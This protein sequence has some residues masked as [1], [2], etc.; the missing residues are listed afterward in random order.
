MNLRPDRS[1][2]RDELHDALSAHFGDDQV[3]MDVVGIELG[4]DFV[5]VI[6]RN[7]ASCDNLLAVIGK[8]QLQLIIANGVKKSPMPAFAKNAGGD[9]TDQQITA[10][11]DDPSATARTLVLANATT[12]ILYDLDRFQ[13][14][15]LLHPDDPTQWQPV[16]AAALAR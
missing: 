15:R 11:F 12:R 4:D 6:E 10:F 5:E 3:F 8:Q 7:V 16:V 14:S 9:L 13:R 2:V 1:G